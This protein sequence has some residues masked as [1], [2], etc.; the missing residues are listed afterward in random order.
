MCA[1]VRGDAARLRKPAAAHGAAEGLFPGVRP[2]VGSQVSGLHAGRNFMT[3]S[4]GQQPVVLSRGFVK[5]FS[6]FAWKLQR[7]AKIV[8]L[9]CSTHPP[10]IRGESRNLADL[11]ETILQNLRYILPCRLRLEGRKKFFKGATY[12]GK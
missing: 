12:L 5:Y 1:H 9:V 8:R 10:T 6:C 3:Y 11:P 4:L 7:S 2:A